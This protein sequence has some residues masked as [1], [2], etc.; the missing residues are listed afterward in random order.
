MVQVLRNPVKQ[1]VREERTRPGPVYRPDADILERAEEYVVLVDVPGVDEG[2]VQVRFDKDVLTIE[3]T[4]AGTPDPAWVARHAE[5][6][7]GAYAREFRIADGHRGGGDPRL[8]QARR[9]RAPPAQDGSPPAPDHPGRSR[10]TRSPREIRG[11]TLDP[12][13]RV[14]DLARLAGLRP[15]KG[16]TGTPEPTHAGRQT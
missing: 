5:Y 8:A 2:S 4:P 15:A 9:A 6:Q 10:L 13:G 14:S 12:A 7:P 16:Y 1:P 11:E 3:A